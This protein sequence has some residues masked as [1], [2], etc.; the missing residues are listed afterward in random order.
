MRVRHAIM[1][2]P[3]NYYLQEFNTCYVR[4]NLNYSTFRVNSFEKGGIQTLA[5]QHWHSNVHLIVAG[6][7]VSLTFC[8]MTTLFS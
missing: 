5:S 8:L 4:E 7:E 2:H 1:T 6:R 3:L